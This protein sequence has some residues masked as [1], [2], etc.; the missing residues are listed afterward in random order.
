MFFVMLCSL[1]VF[2]L[3]AVSGVLIR[4]RMY[5][6]F[7]TLFS[8]SYYFLYVSLVIWLKGLRLLMDRCIVMRLRMCLLFITIVTAPHAVSDRRLVIWKDT[9]LCGPLSI[10]IVFFF[11]S[12]RRHTRLQGDWSSDVCSSD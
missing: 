8:P 9:Y 10:T 5:T 11:S 7:S 3:L 12:R 6:L 4:L 2:R 1:R